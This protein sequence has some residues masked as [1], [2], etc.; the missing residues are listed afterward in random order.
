[1]GYMVIYG[2]TMIIYIYTLVQVGGLEHDW[3]MTF[4]ILGNVIIQT[5][6]HSIIFQRGRYA[7]PVMILCSDLFK[8]I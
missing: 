5:D 8:G 1:M 6:F 7:Q 4:H 2:L 3:I